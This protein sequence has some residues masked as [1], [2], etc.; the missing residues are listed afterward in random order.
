M[1]KFPRAL[2]EKE[3]Y[4]LFKVLPENK[5]GYRK[6]RDKIEELVVIGQGRFSRDNMILGMPGK[7]PDLSFPSTPVFAIGTV[8]CKETQIDIA[9][10]EEIDNEIEFD[11]STNNAYKP[12]EDLTE[13][14]NWSY[15]EWVPG[16]D[17]PND[18]SE[19]KE[20]GVIPGGLIL[21]I[22]PKHKKIWLHNIE[23]GVNHLIPLSN[24]YNQLMMVRDIRNTKVALNPG[25]FFDQLDNY[26]DG[27]LV[28]AL[29]TYNKYIKRFNIDLSY[30]EKSDNKPSQK[31]LFS[32]LRRGKN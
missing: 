15:S 21:T 16:M 5:S 9:I 25:L 13:L 24:F 14:S 28:S 1:D 8:I 12:D 32:F 10:H 26:S 20:V 30:F 3:K 31:S 19:V 27:D 11:I 4:L 18:N 17:A 2:T 7:K 6:Y 22:A 29:I 23:T